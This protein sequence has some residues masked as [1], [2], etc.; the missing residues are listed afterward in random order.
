MNYMQNK[1]EDKKYKG[2]CYL[3]LET[4]WVSIKHMEMVTETLDLLC[5]VAWV[6]EQRNLI[7]DWVIQSGG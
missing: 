7:A 4:Q 6:V 3:W 2:Y 1:E 5:P